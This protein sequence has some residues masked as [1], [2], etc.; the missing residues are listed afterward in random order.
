MLTTFELLQYIFKDGFD[1]QSFCKI[2]VVSSYMLFES[3]EYHSHSLVSQ[4]KFRRNSD[5]LDIVIIIKYY[6]PS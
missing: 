6:F 3:S 2:S 4:K 1:I 5:L